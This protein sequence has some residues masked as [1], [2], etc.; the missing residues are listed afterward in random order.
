[1]PGRGRRGRGQS[2]QH[3]HQSPAVDH[4]PVSQLPLLWTWSLA[5]CAKQSRELW[6]TQLQATSRA[7]VVQHLAPEG[8]PSSEVRRQSFPSSWTRA[9][10]PPFAVICCRGGSRAG[11]VNVRDLA[12]NHHAAP[13]QRTDHAVVITLPKLDISFSI[14][15]SCRLIHSS[16]A[17]YLEQLSRYYGCA[18]NR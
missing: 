7:A 8:R 5:A 2:L 9:L 14:L 17:L 18:R 12:S 11:A 6:L 10:Q 15:D 13:E 4:P 16:F 1:M 3:Q